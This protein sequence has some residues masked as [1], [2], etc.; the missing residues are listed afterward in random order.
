MK[1]LK[2]RAMRG[3]LARIISQAANL[4]LR[5]ATL[6]ILARL[7]SPK[8]FGLVGMVTA[9]VGV[10]TVFR[11]FGLSA[12][13]VQ[14]ASISKEQSSTLFWINVAV[15]LC[16]AIVTAS[17]GPLLARFYHEPRLV[18]VTGVLATAF[19]FN[20]AGVQHSAM[21]ER[22]MHFVMLSTMDIFALIVSTSVGVGMALRGYGYWA[23]LATSTITPLV[24]T[25]CV[26][27]GAR[28]VPERPRRGQ[29]ILSMM[30]FGGTLTL[31]GLIMYFAQNLDKILLG[32]YWGVEALGIY[33]RAYQ[34]VNIPTDNLNSAAGGVAFAALS[35]V[36]DQPAR[37]RSFFLKG[38]SLV[39]SLTVPIAIACTLFA[40][41]IIHVFL[42][43]KWA[44]A[45]PVFR[46]L[47]PVTLAFAIFSPLNW[48]ITSCGFV[49]RGLKMALVL[50]TLLATGYLIG[51][52]WGPRG[53]ATAYSAV[54]LLSV[55]PLIAWS[56]RGT[57]VALRDALVTI[58][59]P[60]LAGSVGGAAA[61]VFHLLCA[62]ALPSL[63]RLAADTAVLA[64][65]YLSFLFFAMSQKD[66]YF[67]LFRSF[68]E[69]RST[70][71]PAAVSR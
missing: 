58:G 19:L 42:G 12:A 8:D 68:V 21:L 9:V 63:A 26:W 50:G 15:G 69:S 24:Y 39:L 47:A 28:W 70:E 51:L 43:A 25:I 32:R 35:R 16:L 61:L 37:L 60:L 38:Y 56:V 71:E 31:N 6:M 59:R 53:V 3:G 54:M 45:V 14:R 36:Q 34:L 52:H 48:L 64:A 49:G 11:D 40:S 27:V 33:G 30:R 66:F 23:L 41:D 20:A 7:L 29:G 22:Q 44:G 55:I 4:L 17:I 67:E 57:P 1:D 2:Q 5:T 46:L 62:P 65:V 13:A 10:F 18:G